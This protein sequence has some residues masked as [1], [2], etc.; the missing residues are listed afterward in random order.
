MQLEKIGVGR[1]PLIYL[2]T[3]RG[4]TMTKFKGMFLYWNFYRN[5]NSHLWYFWVMSNILWIW[6][7]KMNFFF[8]MFTCLPAT[9]GP[10]FF[11]KT[12][13]PFSQL[14][15]RH[16]RDQNT[17]DFVPMNDWVEEVKRKM[18][19]GVEKWAKKRTIWSVACLF[20][21]WEGYFDLF[22]GIGAQMLPAIKK[23]HRNDPIETIGK[24]FAL[25]WKKS[26]NPILICN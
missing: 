4:K 15:I 24:I 3:H 26:L 12:E 19:F 16:V 14:I 8:L 11:F 22:K 2:T 1:V 21:N 9:F 5:S 20:R 13:I 25:I 10:H 23:F 6:I 17:I 7:A 18:R